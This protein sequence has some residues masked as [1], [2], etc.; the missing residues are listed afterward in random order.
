M[1]Q[2]TTIPQLP[3]EGY[4]SVSEPPK[5]SHEGWK[6]IISTL[7]ILLVAPLIAFFLT[8]F[9]F[10]S[11]EV[12]GAS[13]ETTLQNMDRLV[14]LKTGKTWAKITGDAYIPKRTDIIIFEKNDGA[15]TIQG[16]GRQLIKRV[17]GLPGDHVVVKD[18][19]ITVYN[20]ASPGGFNPDEVGGYSKNVPNIT[21]GNV[22][23]TVGENELFVCG[24][25][26]LNSFDSRS[27]GTI[28]S[29]DIIGRL[30]LRLYPFSK[31]DSF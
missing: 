28:S 9:V 30:A 23:I 2:E 16:G 29:D 3:N 8:A 24:D 19:K 27:F 4:M 21:P 7:L 17:V 10:Q 22:D 26:R 25:N 5:N 6:S 13:M 15:T 11:Y 1:Q 14:V 31:F 12:E 18:G 20:D